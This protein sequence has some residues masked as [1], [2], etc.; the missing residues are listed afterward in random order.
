M[1]YN[2]G[3]VSITLFS[4]QNTVHEIAHSEYSNQHRNMGWFCK[5]REFQSNTNK[6]MIHCV[7]IYYCEFLLLAFFQMEIKLLK[8]V[9]LKAFI[10]I[11]FICARL[12]KYLM[13]EHL[14]RSI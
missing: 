12:N 9:L 5:S 2:R 4:Q 3:Y 10:Q 7:P 14:N 6:W 1:L 11:S 8:I 13:D